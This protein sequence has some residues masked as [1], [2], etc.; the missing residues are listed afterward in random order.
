MDC[1]I[2]EDEENSACDASYDE[3]CYAY[4]HWVLNNQDPDY[5]SEE[6]CY[7]DSCNAVVDALEA[8]GDDWFE[9]M[10]LSPDPQ[11]YINTEHCT[12]LYPA[13]FVP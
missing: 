4:C 2:V 12:N 11:D 6:L 1:D 8:E 10:I 5:Y 7:L 9:C 13:V 3:A